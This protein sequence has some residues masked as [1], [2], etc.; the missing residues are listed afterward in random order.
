M[1]RVAVLTERQIEGRVRY[2]ETAADEFERF[3]QPGMAH[4][5]REDAERWRQRLPKPK[6]ATSE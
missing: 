5:S 2:H 4:S 6:E 3:G 1:N